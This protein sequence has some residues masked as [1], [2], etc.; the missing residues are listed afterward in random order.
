MEKLLAFDFE[1]V[2]PGHGRRFH[3]PAR[4]MREQLEKLVRL[5][6]G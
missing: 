6:K 5:M 3:A 4:R 2:L 1:W